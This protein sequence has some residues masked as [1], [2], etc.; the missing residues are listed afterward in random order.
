MVRLE[1]RTD[2]DKERDNGQVVHQRL[3]VGDLEGHVECSHQH[4]ENAAR[5][6]NCA[7]HHHDLVDDVEVGDVVVL[8]DHIAVVAEQVGNVG[9]GGG[10]PASS[11]V[12]E[13][14]YSV[15]ML[16]GILVKIFC[17]Y[18][19][20]QFALF[21]NAMHYIYLYNTLFEVLKTN[22]LNFHLVILSKSIYNLFLIRKLLSC[23]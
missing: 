16:K 22:P 7:H 9:N 8:G 19:R 3:K 5:A 1:E 6:Q 13:L 20:F 21:Y 18:N 12:V 23:Y 10:H 15:I 2:K 11:L 14:L 17:I 4:E